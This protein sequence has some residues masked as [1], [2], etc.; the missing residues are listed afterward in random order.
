MNICMQPSNAPISTF[1]LIPTTPTTDN[2]AATNGRKNTKPKVAN[3]E[4]R[5]AKPGEMIWTEQH[6]VMCAI[7][8]L[9]RR[10]YAEKKGTVAAGKAWQDIANVLNKSSNQAVYFSVDKK[11]VA[12][13]YRLML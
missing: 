5:A 2:G 8:I 11:S 9:A 7:E 12:D 1:P 6:D 4:G 3:C 13:H 10:P